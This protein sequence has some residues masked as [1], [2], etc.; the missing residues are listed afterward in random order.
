MRLADFDFFLPPERIAQEPVRPRDAARL[1]HVP[2]TGG[3]GHRRM[4]DLPAL[5]R[6]G[7]V[8][9]ANDSKVIPA[10][11]YGRR[12]PAR[13]ELL[14]HKPLA[15]G[16]WE[17]FARPARRL[18]AGD[19]IVIGDDFSARLLEH[20]GEGRVRL[21]FETRG[22]FHELLRRH[23]EAPLPPYIR[24]A[25]GE[26]DV[27]DYQTIYARQDGSVAA[28][29]AGL[30]FTPALLQ[31]LKERSVGFVPLTLHVGAGTFLPVKTERIEEHAM[32]AEAG[33]VSEKAAAAINAAREKGGRVV[34]VGTTS[35]R[36]LETAGD[37]N[38][39]VSPWKGET[40]I[41]LYPGARFRAVDLLLTNFHLPK[42]TLFML[43]CAFAGTARMKEAYAEAI[44]RDYRFYSYGDACLLEK[45]LF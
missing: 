13:V 33:E 9:V 35:C 31:A 12:G 2:Q 41:F 14:L 40:Q 4:A 32:H 26:S 30:H 38:G 10:R 36:L 34:A 29:T 27:E 5:L 39:R 7:D 28:P 44:A 1:L 37:E 42:S 45:A 18:R 11:L 21:A 22:D 6:P 43:V 8:L 24:R 23:G 25:A 20:E 17:A 19:E 15:R 16:E 3:P